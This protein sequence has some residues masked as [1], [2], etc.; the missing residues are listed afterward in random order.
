M[1]IALSGPWQQP[2]IDHFLSAN[3]LPV[4]VSCVGSD[5]FPRVV[6]LWYQYRSNALY[7]VTHR[8]SKII[9]LLERDGRVGFE[10]APDAPPYHGVRGQGTATISPLGDSPLLRDLLQA[11]LGDLSS[12]LSGW[13]LSRSAQEV[14]I[15][16]S[17]HRLYS[18][19]YRERMSGEP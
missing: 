17:P 8:S 3:S 18:W 12:P 6:S 4:R 16:I 15:R 5:G 1:S 14:I 11:Y 2:Q 7:C 13:L 9:T 19:D 10:V